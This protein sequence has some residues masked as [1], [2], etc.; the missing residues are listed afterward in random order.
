MGDKRGEATDAGDFGG[1]WRI[2][3][4]GEMNIW[5]FRGGML[6]AGHTIITTDLLWNYKTSGTGTDP[7]VGLWR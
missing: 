4:E 1:E 5:T 7:C 3:N 6:A 2:E